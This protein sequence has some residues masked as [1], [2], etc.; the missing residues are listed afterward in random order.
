MKQ[1]VF[2]PVNGVVS[3]DVQE[4]FNHIFREM[5]ERVPK[6]TQIDVIYNNMSGSFTCKLTFEDKTNNLTIDAKTMLPDYYSIFVTHKEYG[7]IAVP[8]DDKLAND[9]IMTPMYEIS[10]EEIERLIK[11][12]YLPDI[13][14]YYTFDFSTF[15]GMNKMSKK[16]KKKLNDVLVKLSE[17]LKDKTVEDTPRFRISKFNSVDDFE[18]TSDERCRNPLAYIGE[19]SGW[20]ANATFEVKNGQ[21]VQKIQT[22]A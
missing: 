3:N 1:K 22:V 12:Y 18:I 11:N 8:F 10:K 21:A 2:T 13:G 5:K 20:T 16:D 19:T 4:H 7:T 6:G 17:D 14:V 15:K 9:I